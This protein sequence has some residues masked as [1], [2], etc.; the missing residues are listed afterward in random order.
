LVFLKS[1]KAL[2]KVGLSWGTYS[3]GLELFTFF[4]ISIGMTRRIINFW[5][6]ITFY[7]LEYVSKYTF[8]LPF[9]F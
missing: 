5:A 9:A 3:R 2:K 7:F 1:T 8:Y 4:G 6:K